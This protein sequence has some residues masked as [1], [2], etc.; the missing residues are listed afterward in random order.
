L[1]LDGGELRAIVRYAPE[2]LAETRGD[3][4]LLRV[5]MPEM[6]RAGE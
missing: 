6:G 1:L 5:F 4:E 2:R 3:F